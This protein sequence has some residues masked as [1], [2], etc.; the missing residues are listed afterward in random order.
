MA[1]SSVERRHF[2]RGKI[3]ITYEEGQGNLVPPKSLMEL[4][5]TLSEPGWDTNYPHFNNISGLG[6]VGL[7]GCILGCLL[8]IHMMLLVL[9]HSLL[10][11]SVMHL[12][13]V[14][15]IV[16]AAHCFMFPI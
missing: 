16:S 3:S 13:F 4:L 2:Q 1:R 15:V 5:G 14:F 7:C 11:V 12:F 8:G 6:I 10:V 9:T